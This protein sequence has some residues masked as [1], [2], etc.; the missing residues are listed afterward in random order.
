MI[1]AVVIDDENLARSLI[2]DYIAEVPFMDCIGSYA[3]PLNAIETLQDGD[4]DLILMAMVMVM[5]I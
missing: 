1:K 5:L 4:V 3:N 2:E